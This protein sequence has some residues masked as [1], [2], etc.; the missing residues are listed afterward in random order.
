MSAS[1]VS[2]TVVEAKAGPKV[3]TLNTTVVLVPQEAAEA[4]EVKEE[5]RVAASD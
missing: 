3:E 1:E 4:A 2:V 5:E